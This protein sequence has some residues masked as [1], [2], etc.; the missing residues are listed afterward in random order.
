MWGYYSLGQI[1]ALLAWLDSGRAAEQQL[2]DAIQI[3]YEPALLV[4]GNDAAEPRGLSKE[5]PSQVK[6][7]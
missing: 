7:V 2:A 6:R 4:H 1:P 3:I 5:A